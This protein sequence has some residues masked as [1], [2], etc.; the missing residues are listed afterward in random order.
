MG[1]AT[2][3]GRTI[4]AV[5]DLRRTESVAALRSTV[6]DAN[7][8]QFI[9]PA[10]PL[11]VLVVEAQGAEPSRL[12]FESEAKF[13][14]FYLSTLRVNATLEPMRRVQFVLRDVSP[15]FEHT[16]REATKDLAREFGGPNSTQLPLRE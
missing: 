6:G 4:A 5:F 15:A 8:R 14:T 1:N 12:A 7:I 3:G 2:A 11:V 10:K 9:D 16:V 13:L